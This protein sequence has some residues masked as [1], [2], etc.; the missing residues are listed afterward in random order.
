MP[1]P[2]Y[3]KVA[4]AETMVVVQIETAAAVEALPE[5]LQVPGVDVYFIGPN[6]LSQSLGYPA[7]PEEPA[8]QEV[9]EQALSQILAAGKTAGIMV[10]DAAGMRRYRERGARYITVSAPGLIAPA[11]RAFVAAGRE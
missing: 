8:V 11:A 6:D 5:M 10:R 1:L 2:E 4:N 9:I 7:R 3:V